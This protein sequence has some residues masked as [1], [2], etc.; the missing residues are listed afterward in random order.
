MEVMMSTKNTVDAEKIMG[1]LDLI[2]D[3]S[4]FINDISGVAKSIMSKDPGALDGSVVE[5]II[6][7]NFGESMYDKIRKT[8][9]EII[10][11]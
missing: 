4:K 10:G 1:L 5:H 9:I 8:Y 11:T 6:K 3:N 7:S 2:G